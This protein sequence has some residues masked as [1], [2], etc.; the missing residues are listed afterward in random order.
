LEKNLSLVG[1]VQDI[2][3]EGFSKK[4]THD[5]LTGRTLCN[6]VVNFPSGSVRVGEIVPVKIIEAFSH[7]LLGYPLGGRNDYADK[8]GGILHAA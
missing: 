8:K 6:K 4:R 5:Q 1:T 7:S 2:L 3:A